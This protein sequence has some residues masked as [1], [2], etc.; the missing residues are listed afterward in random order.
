[1]ANAYSSDGLGIAKFGFGSAVNPVSYT[2]ASATTLT[3][4]SYI[5]MVTGTVAV[6]NITLPWPGFEGPLTLI[7]TNA[8]PAAT[9][10]GGTTGIAIAKATTV[11][12][13]LALEMVYS[14]TSGLWYPSY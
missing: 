6:Q 1:M 8:T 4:V 7:F 9:L 11:V 5:T 14:A 12:Q 13:Y 2:L 10:T 3:P